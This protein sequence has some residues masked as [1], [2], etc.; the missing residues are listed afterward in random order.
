MYTPNGIF[1]F[2]WAVN[3]AGVFT[4]GIVQSVPSRMFKAKWFVPYLTDTYSIVPRAGRPIRWWQRSQ[5]TAAVGIKLE[6]THDHH[7]VPKLRL[8]DLMEEKDV[9]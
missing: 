4:E 7:S 1:L 3:I 8:R 2:I 6:R 9:R 5:L